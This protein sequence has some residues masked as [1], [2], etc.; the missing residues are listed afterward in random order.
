MI[1]TISFIDLFNASQ[2]SWI[3][4]DY[5]LLVSHLQTQSFVLFIFVIPLFIYFLL[6]FWV[7]VHCSIYKCSY[8]VSNMSYLNSYGRY[9]FTIL[10]SLHIVFHSGCTSLHSHQQYMR[11]PFTPTSSPIFVV[12]GVIEERGRILVWFW[13]AFPLWPRMVNIFHLFCNHLDFFL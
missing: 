8:N 12:Y 9:S 6:L 2:D 4:F 5:V 13:F 10:R 7:W 1:A 11:V 3:N